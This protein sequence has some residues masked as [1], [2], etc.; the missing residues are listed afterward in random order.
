MFERFGERARQVVVAAQGE[1]RSLCHDHIG[2]EHLLVGALREDET[3]GGAVLESLEL[4]LSDLR[5]AVVAVVGRSGAASPGQLPF[6]PRARNAL[7][8]SLLEALGANPPTVAPKHLLLGLLRIDESV[9]M[10][11]L[12]GL[13]IDVEE[14]RTLAMSL[15]D[16]RWSKGPPAAR[17]AGP[18]ARR[19]AAQLPLAAETRK[20][21]EFARDEARSLRHASVGPEHLLLALVCAGEGPAARVLAW[22]GITPEEVGAEL[23][24]LFESAEAVRDGQIPFTRRARRA[25]E[26][27]Q[28]E[29]CALHGRAVAPEHV[30][31][32]LVREKQ[33]AAVARRVRREVVRQLS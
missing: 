26:L 22:L 1:A 18:R 16:D 11:V 4:T 13:D 14:L 7:E 6:T 19:L 24:G 28:R 20:V 21:L 31:L 2:S 25:L 8:L 27:A 30:L 32:G 17:A 5:A 3:H 9:A 12:D 33:G 23:A 15:T 29:A 10:R